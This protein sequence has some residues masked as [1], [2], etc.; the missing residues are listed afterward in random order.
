MRRSSTNACSERSRRVAEL[1]A[2]LDGLKDTLLSWDHVYETV[3]P[4]KALGYKT[5]DQFYQDWSTSHPTRKE[6]LSDMS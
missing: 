3:R 1:P 4:H 2:D 6:A 5:P